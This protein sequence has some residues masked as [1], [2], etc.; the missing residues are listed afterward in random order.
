MTILQAQ[1]ANCELLFIKSKKKHFRETQNKRMSSL[2]F[3]TYNTFLNKVTVFDRKFNSPTILLANIPALYSVLL[4]SLQPAYW[5][6]GILSLIPMSRDEIFAFAVSWM[7][8]YNGAY[9]L[10]SR[11]L[12]YS[13]IRYAW[14]AA[15]ELQKH[16]PRLCCRT[17]LL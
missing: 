9:P 15:N 3:I 11:H 14:Q 12:H 1:N 7:A 16:N 13:R 17:T 2:L 10:M 5:L 6:N 8:F 4:F